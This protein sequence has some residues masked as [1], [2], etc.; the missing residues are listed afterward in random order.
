MTDLIDRNL[1][2]EAIEKIWQGDGY[3]RGGEVIN[4][5]RSQPSVTPQGGCI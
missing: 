3:M 2:I 5:L 1:A 4:T